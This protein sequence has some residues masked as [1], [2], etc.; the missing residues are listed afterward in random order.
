MKKLIKK[1]TTTIVALGVAGTMAA[2]PVMAAAPQE[3]LAAQQEDTIRYLAELAKIFCMD[4]TNIQDSEKELSS[5]LEQTVESI[6]GENIKED[7]ENI[8]DGIGEAIA[9]LLGSEVEMVGLYDDTLWDDTVFDDEDV[10]A[11][12]DLMAMILGEDEGRVV[13]LDDLGIAIALES[14]AAIKEDKDGFVYIYATEDSD[15]PCVVISRSEDGMSIED[16]ELDLQAVCADEYEDFEL[17]DDEHYTTEFGTEY[18]IETCT[19]TVDGRPVVDTTLYIGIGDAI[20]AF[21]TEEIAGEESFYDDDYLWGLVYSI[22]LVDDFDAYNLH[23]SASKGIDK[24]FIGLKI[25]QLS[26]TVFGD[27]FGIGDYDDYVAL[28]GLGLA[29]MLGDYAT[30]DYDEDGYVHVYYEEFGKRPYTFIGC[31]EAGVDSHEYINGL[32][33][34][35]GVDD[36]DLDY[37]EHYEDEDGTEYDTLSYTSEEDGALVQCTGLFITIGDVVYVFITDEDVTDGAESFYDDDYLL[38][39]AL[40][41]M[42]LG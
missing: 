35:Y 5:K 11:F 29:L 2:M 1:I 30:I 18:S 33:T 25:D 38:D 20:Y 10:V 41:A 8:L 7:G 16:Y 31:S 39:L 32:L 40:S 15:L 14:Y 34:M 23:V 42:L 37:Y 17:V 27:L 9:G 22:W 6:F 24:P 13:C 4:K 36:E 28:E 12:F 3:A 26:D 19:Y 21:A